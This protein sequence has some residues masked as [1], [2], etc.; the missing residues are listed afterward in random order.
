[1]MSLSF[2]YPFVLGFLLVP[3]VLLVWVWRRS[4]R[5]VALPFDHSG[6]RAGKPL[7]FAINLAECLPALLLAIAIVLLAGPQRLGDPETKRK[8]TNIELLV[9]VSGSMMTPFGDGSRYDTS[10]RAIESFLGYRK[11]DAIGLTFFG[12]NVI[13]WVPLTTDSSAVKCAPPFMRPENAPPWMH[14]TLIAKALRACRKVLTERQEGERMI[15]MV[16]DGDSF[17]LEN[18]EDLVVA[19]E[20]KAANIVLYSIHVSDEP[21]PDQITNITGLTGGDVF[22]PDSAEALP[23]VFA[24]IDQMQQAPMERKLGELKDDFGLVSI[25]G[26]SLLALAGLAMFGARYTPW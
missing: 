12:N 5:R 19:K 25:V 13:H 9:D 10:M 23:H 7:W 8:A 3:A 15:V 1:M 18:G 6:I 11:G 24:R 16:T 21:V 17:D 2:A 22:A 14:G 26:L 4:D 20:L